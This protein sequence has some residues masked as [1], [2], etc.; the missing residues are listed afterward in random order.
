MDHQTER[1]DRRCRGTPTGGTA[2][3]GG[4]RVGRECAPPGF[5]GRAPR[6]GP[7]GL[8]ADRAW[9]PEARRIG[10]PG[11]QTGLRT[12]GRR[13]ARAG[14]PERARRTNRVSAICAWGLSRPRQRR[15]LVDHTSAEAGGDSSNRTR[16]RSRRSWSAR[17]SLGTALRLDRLP[18]IHEAL[19]TSSGTRDPATAMVDATSAGRP[20]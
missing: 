11:G 2:C 7:Q 12:L 20:A 5:P 13:V 19:R 10:K 14:C 9:A 16:E 18:E 8:D 1:P 4:D 3:A 15:P 6:P 17:S